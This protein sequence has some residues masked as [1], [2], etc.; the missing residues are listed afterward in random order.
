[1]CNVVDSHCHLNDVC[2][3]KHQAEVCV[4]L[5]EAFSGGVLFIQNICTSVRGF[6]VVHRV[7][8]ENSRVF[9]SIGV[10]PH[11]VLEYG[12]ADFDTIV[13]CAGYEKVTCIG[14]TGLD[15]S[16]CPSEH[17]R[18]MQKENFLVH[19]VASQKTGLPLIVHTRDAEHDTAEILH[20]EYIKKAFPI[21]VHCLTSSLQF[22]LECLP[23]V[24]AFSA[25][26]IIT[27][28]NAI[29]LRDVFA[30]I[31]ENKLLLETDAPYLTPVPHRGKCNCPA[32]VVHVCEK[33]AEIRGLSCAEMARAT[34]GNFMR[35]FSKVTGI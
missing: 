9:A 26:G 13:R 8:L 33:L 12:I 34:T 11:D 30:R 6:D 14:E 15:Y 22:V 5:E 2:F 1:M 27:F 3:A 18:A 32:Y 20:C 35:I 31:P 25:S 17:E 4:V 29:E 10:H 21:V 19:I 23:I 24:E 16:E 7:A 28:K